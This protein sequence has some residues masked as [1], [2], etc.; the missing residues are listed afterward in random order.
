MIG[1][2]PDS[3][4]CFMVSE[5]ERLPMAGWP[6]DSLLQPAGPGLS[7]IEL[8]C[9]RTV[10]I[11]AQYRSAIPSGDA[12]AAMATARGLGPIYMCPLAQ[13]SRAGGT[14]MRAASIGGD[15]RRCRRSGQRQHIGI[16]ACKVGARP[17]PTRY[18]HSFFAQDH[19]TRSASYRLVRI[20]LGYTI[21]DRSRCAAT[22]PVA[23]S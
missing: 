10:L 17:Y 1:N 21:Q 5:P 16:S 4:G 11:D 8:I 3:Q 12:P 13:F 19:L 22:I 7:K 15:V 2:Q 18:S 6:A 20:N 14:E 23:S 9:V